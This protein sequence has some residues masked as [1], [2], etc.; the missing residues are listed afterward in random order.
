MNGERTQHLHVKLE[1]QK[2]KKKQPDKDQVIQKI[3]AQDWFYVLW[4]LK[5]HFVCL[6]NIK[7]SNHVTVYNL[8][9]NI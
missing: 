9:E 1:M 7:W 4:S 6:W 2:M 3:Q 8:H 5:S